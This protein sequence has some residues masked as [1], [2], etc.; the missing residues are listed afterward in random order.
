MKIV[1]TAGPTREPLDPVRFLSNRSS[2]KM[3]YALVEAALELGHEA[4]LISG[5]TA[6][7]PP[8]QANF[9]GITTSDELYDA[10]HAQL[11]DCDLLIM[12]AAVCD[13][14]PVEVASQKTKKHKGEFALRLKPARDIL[15]SLPRTARSYFVVGF[16]AETHDL[17]KHAR[18]KL[19]AKNCDAIVANDVSAADV[20]MESDEN[21]VTIFFRDGSSETISRAPK[22]NI[23][24]A[25]LKNVFKTMKKVLTKKT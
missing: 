17:E 25:I 8:P 16:A 2:A 7:K 14:R 13:Y 6:L 11:R 20:G 12:C 10:V 19:I 4:T 3:G 9:I 22:K 21:A 5:P 18:A 1:V 23:A 15:C 24:R